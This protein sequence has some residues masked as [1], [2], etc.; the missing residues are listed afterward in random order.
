[1]WSAQVISTLLISGLR[2]RICACAGIWQGKSPF[3]TS[4]FHPGGTICM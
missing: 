4:A 1:L 2:S 3:S